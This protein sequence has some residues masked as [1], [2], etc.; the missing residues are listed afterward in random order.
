LDNFSNAETRARAFQIDLSFYNEIRAAKQRFKLRDKFVIPPYSGRGFLVKRGQTFRVIEEA[1]PQIGDVA[2]WNAENPEEQFGGMRTWL[3]EGWIIRINT[4]LWSELPWFRPMMTCVD[5]TVVVPSDARYHHHF[6]EAHCSP[7][8]SERKYGAVGLNGCRVNLLQAIEPF[9][10]TEAN[11]RENIN[12]HEKDWRDPLTDQ[13]SIAR[14]DAK[15]GDYVEFYAEM[16]LIVGV[17]V[18]PYGDGLG[19]PTM[20][21]V[22]VVKPLGIEIYDTGIFPIQFP[23]WLR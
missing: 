2:F 16:D 21:G 14:G 18:C 10:L 3:V 8:T 6:I 13:Q 1:G 20:R 9:G 17:S 19:N 23:S 11:L 4:R 15:P 7:E 22:D 5:D 12:V